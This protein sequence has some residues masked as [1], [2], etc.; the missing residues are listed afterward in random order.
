[1]IYKPWDPAGFETFGDGTPCNFADYPGH[2]FRLNNAAI[3]LLVQLQVYAF[4]LFLFH[5]L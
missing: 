3:V 4:L 1:M 2:A 5:C